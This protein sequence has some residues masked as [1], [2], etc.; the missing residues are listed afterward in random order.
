MSENT[1]RRRSTQEA[2]ADGTRR[3]TSIPAWR[4]RLYRIPVLGTI[5]H[6]IWPPSAS[7]G[8]VRKVISGTLVIIAVLGIGMAAYPWAGEKYPGF[9][10]IPV[11]KLIEWSNVLSDLQTNRLQDQL[12]KDF[13][14]LTTIGLNEG[15]PLTRFQIPKLG[16]DT[17]VVQGTSPSA[18]RAGAGHYP[19]TPLPGQKGNVAIA[20]HR[21]TYGRPFNRIDQLKVGD[22]IILTTP[23][24]RYTY[25]VSRP[26]FITTPFDWTI[27]AKSKDPILTLTTCH[28]KGSAR[29]RLVV[30]AKLVRSEPVRR[31]A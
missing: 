22:K 20:G 1:P 16:V 10:R 18:L 14:N 28:P 6:V 2:V 17:I 8:W 12:A 19:N 31:A 25:A 23:V 9:Y 3:D 15:D 13:A 4:Q 7:S 27:I 11:E 26:P 30:R 5:T 24:G 21:T 29:E